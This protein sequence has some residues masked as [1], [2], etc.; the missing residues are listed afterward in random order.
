MMAVFCGVAALA[1]HLWPVYLDFKG[2]KGVATAAGIVFA[3]NWMA[4]LAALAAWLVVFLPFRYVSLASVSAAVV[5][6]LVQFVT[7]ESL[8]RERHWPV[9]VFCTFAAFLVVYR[10]R[11]NLRRLMKGEEKKFHFRREGSA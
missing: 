5:L 11:D 10:H 3:L 6:P 8:W 7:R 4:G 1:G 9:T 2:G